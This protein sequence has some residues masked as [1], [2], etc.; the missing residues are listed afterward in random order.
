M[1]KESEKGKRDC[2]ESRIPS[3]KEYDVVLGVY[4]NSFYWMLTGCIYK[5]WILPGKNSER[6][7]TCGGELGKLTYL[8]LR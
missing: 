7:Q 6:V 5:P 8:G 4:T 3:L 2:G 1:K